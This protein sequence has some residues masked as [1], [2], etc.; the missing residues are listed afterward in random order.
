MCAFSV[1]TWFTHQVK[2]LRARR[3]RGILP[4][5]PRL[6]LA[7]LN[8]ADLDQMPRFV[9]D[10]PIAVRYL[11]L[12]EGLDWSHF[13]DRLPNRRWPD[14]LPLASFAV[15][16]LIKLD[17][18]LPS[19]G[20]LRQY[21]VDHPALIWMLG[22]PLVTN[23]RF[24]WGFDAHAS[25]PT[26][27]HLSRLLRTIRNTRL[28]FLLDCT[29]H[30]L[31]STLPTDVAFGRCISLDTK[32]ILAWVKENNPKAY[33]KR[34]ERFDKARQPK[35]DRD[36][37][38]GCKRKRN[39]RTSTQDLPFTPLTDAVPANTI[40]VGEYYW[41]YGSG[42]VA[43]KVPGWGEFVL[44]E[45]TQPFDCSD[46]SYFFPLMAD[47][48]RRLGF[49]PRFGAFDT[50]FDA[51]YV[52][53][54]FHRDDEQGGFAAVPFSQKG[55]YKRSFSPDGL[56]LC[57]AG[58]PMPLKFT[59]MARKG[60]LVE[61]EK[62]RHACPLRFP[63]L[64][65]R[66][67]PIDHERWL[68]GGCTTTL[69]TSIGARIRYQLDRQGDAYKQVYKQRTATERINSQAVDLGIERPK[70]RNG[71]SIAN[72]NTLTY[73]LINLRALQRVRRQLIRQQHKS[74]D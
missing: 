21:L 50:A 53:E 14:A 26:V 66:V 49:R 73:V 30:C 56:P 3:F 24:P 61:H 43:T 52:Y 40:A 28:Q 44:A 71:R 8:E 42:V 58:L 63:E 11:C 9:R 60:C 68:K 18:H 33:H 62:G 13:P 32:H 41:G 7:L 45:L 51:F 59:F 4:T 70:L 34:S 39:Q 31:Q 36:C 1:S 55:G 48:E 6:R 47:V 22:F 38:L 54:Y 2:T 20:H 5:E 46:V 35:G 67:C 64:T 16:Y 27:R 12:F 10:C 25:L 69:P 17:Q 57:K 74:A 37:R 65:D 29:V 19:M 23:P 15:A 72:H